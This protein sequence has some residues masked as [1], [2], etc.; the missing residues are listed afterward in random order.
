MSTDALLI[1]LKLRGFASPATLETMVGVPVGDDLAGLQADGLVSASKFGLR[2]T[3]SGQ[4]TAVD[5]WNAAHERIGGAAMAALYGDFHAPNLAFKALVADWQ[6]RNG[7]VN[8]HQDAAYDA[9]VL[10]RLAAIDVVIRP[11]IARAA[12]LEPRLSRYADRLA[13]ALA[14]I[15]AGDRRFVAAPLLDSYHTIWFE[16]HEELIRLAGLSRAVEAAE[17]RA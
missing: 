11:L 2:L 15:D 17:G 10:V 1:A 6:L 3:P 13:T 12:G 8:D 16:L 4:A 14:A 7:A 9:T 5:C